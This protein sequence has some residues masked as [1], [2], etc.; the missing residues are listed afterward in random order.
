VTCK[1]SQGS[2]IKT[3]AFAIPEVRFAVSNKRTGV[4]CRFV[5]CVAVVC[6]K[7]VTRVAQT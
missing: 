6:E 1:T 5:S 4:Q 7:D 2:R 3:P